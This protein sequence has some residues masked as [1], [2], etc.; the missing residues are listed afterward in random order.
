MRLSQSGPLD[1]QVLHITD[2]RIELQRLEKERSGLSAPKASPQADAD[3]Q[4]KDGDTQAALMRLVDLIQRKSE[5][6]RKGSSNRKVRGRSPKPST[7][8]QAYKACRDLIDGPQSTGL[9]LNK[10]V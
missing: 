5:K 7:S 2:H 9:T 4:P 10:F 8:I 1:A 6:Q 3:P